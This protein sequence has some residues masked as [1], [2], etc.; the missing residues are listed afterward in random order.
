[1]AANYQQQLA[2][3]SSTNRIECIL[4]ILV[5]VSLPLENLLPAI[6][7]FSLAF[8]AFGLAA[9]SVVVFRLQALKKVLRHPLI[10]AWGLLLLVGVGMEMT[11]EK[12][13][14]AYVFRLAQMVAGAVVIA[15]LAR[16]RR[17][18][19]VSFG[20]FVVVGMICAAVLYRSGGGD[21][22]QDEAEGFYEASVARENALKDTDLSK[23]LNRLAFIM[24]VSGALGIT[25]AISARSVFS[26]AVSGTAGLAGLIGSFLTV[27]RS[28]VLIALVPIAVVLALRKKARMS[29]L[30][31]AGGLAL[32]VTLLAPDVLWERM[33]VGNVDRL[34]RQEIRGA[35]YIDFAT[36]A[37][38]YILNGI[39][40][41]DYWSEWAEKVI[42]RRL[43]AHNAVLHV[44][45]LW[46]FPALLGFGVMAWVTYRTLP[47]FDDADLVSVGLW[48]VVIAASLRLLVTHNLYTK[49][50]SVVFGLVI[51]ARLWLYNSPN[52][53]Q[54]PAR[55]KRWQSKGGMEPSSIAGNKGKL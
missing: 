25:L 37:E 4:L 40:E 6:G 14:F 52:Q 30:L 7:P 8:L 35:L 54:V 18:V 39:G 13:G 51:A 22:Y 3:K 38:D 50:F 32:A 1:M 26:R 42:G 44:T 17:A 43:G 53:T 29:S 41:T 23:D 48:T 19:L 24:A 5:I 49:E 46:G 45:V 55:T 11:H 27:S 12:P 9:T 28:G 34:G 21:L 20:S 31:W 15:S 10:R 2:N 36:N 33:S 16:D 47:R